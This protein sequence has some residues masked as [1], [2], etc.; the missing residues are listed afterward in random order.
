MSKLGRISQL[1]LALRWALVGM[2]MS[3]LSNA[4]FEGSVIPSILVVGLPAWVVAFR[5]TFGLAVDFASPAAAWIVQR[6]GSFRSLASA[7]GVEG[8]LCLTVALVPGGWE[9]W[10][11]LLLAL[12]CLLLMTGQV[13]DVASEVFEVDAAE[14]DDGML[15][16]YSG[17]VSVISSVA[18]TLLGQVA[19]SAIAN[20]SV[21]AM[22]FTSALLSFGC[23]LTRFRTRDLMPGVTMNTA[24]AAEQTATDA[25]TDAPFRDDTASDHE[26][27]DRTD[28]DRTTRVRLL[29]ASALMALVPAL[30]MSYTMLGLGKE[31]GGA[32]LTVLYACSGVGAIIGS[33]AYMRWSAKLGMRRIG[34]IGVALMAVAL[35]FV[36]IPTLPTAC[37]GWLLDQLGY[38]LL[39][40]A[41][42]M[43][44][45][46]QLRGSD[47]ARFSG[48]A[49]FAYAIGSAAG[50][51]AGWAMSADWRLLAPLA[52]MLCVG[53]LPLFRAMPTSDRR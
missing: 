22:L 26:P 15:V 48:R 38:G 46:L 41:V 49:R 29:A 42:V 30:W 7:E 13:I 5:R 18:G 6:F 4:V 45:M 51:W 44:R 1:S 47:L 35:V 21:K 19:G 8:V 36:A 11:W 32:A 34:M 9:Y 12:S 20:A 52:L 16:Q 3:M 25:T 39:A 37:V 2:T 40:Q 10:K 28:A 27:A 23:A 50:T 53:F 14:G 24:D 31:Y 17:Y 33:F 43:S